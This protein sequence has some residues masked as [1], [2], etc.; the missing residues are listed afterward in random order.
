MYKFKMATIAIALPLIVGAHHG[1]AETATECN[2]RQVDSV[3]LYYQESGK[4][5]LEAVQLYQAHEK[6]LK[7][8]GQAEEFRNFEL[9]S[10]DLAV[11][12]SAFGV[13][14]IDATVSFSLQFDAN[15]AA[16]AKLISE[17]HASGFNSSRYKL[18]ECR[19]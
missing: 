1:L 14:K 5:K 19:Q 6:K 16:V 3:Y 8:I 12:E 9:L 10:Q 4:T 13:N 2:N 17:A 11:N 18:D 15:Y 7:A